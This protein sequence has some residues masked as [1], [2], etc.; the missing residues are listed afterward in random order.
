MGLAEFIKCTNYLVFFLG[1]LLSLRDFSLID[2]N[3]T[4]TIYAAKA[5]SVTKQVK[6]S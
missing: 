4:F 2:L 6:K 3:F 1:F 5:N